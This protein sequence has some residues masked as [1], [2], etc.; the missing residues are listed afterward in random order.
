MRLR[1]SLGCTVL[2]FFPAGACG[3][4]ALREIAAPFPPVRILV[5]K[6]HR[7]SLHLQNYNTHTFSDFHS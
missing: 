1:S 3:V 6:Q 5:R 2:N 4:E 7:L